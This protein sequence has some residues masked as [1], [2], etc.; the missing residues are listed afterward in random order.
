MTAGGPSV[1]RAMAGP[2]KSAVLNCQDKTLLRRREGLSLTA[3]NICAN[4]PV[5]WGV[6]VC[7]R[8]GMCFCKVPV[9]EQELSCHDKTV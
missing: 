6:A 5:V 7:V 1:Y 2:G 9:D 4:G 3:T 8:V